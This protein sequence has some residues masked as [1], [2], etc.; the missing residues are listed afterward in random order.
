MSSAQNRIA[1]VL[2]AT[3]GIGGETAT[4]LT[5]HGWHVRALARR[6]DDEAARRQPG[7]EWVRGDSMDAASVV[8][9]STGASLIVH[10]VNPPG[11]R[12]WDKLVLPML[13]S[14]VQAARASGARILLPGTITTMGRTLGQPCKKT[15]RSIPR[16]AKARS[17][18][19]SSSV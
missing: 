4:A 17:G 3:G 15:S 18:C 2:G 11:Y 14:T 9:A 7:W 1:L 12:H 10:A 6:P 16:L 19:S 8:R 5:R 13:E